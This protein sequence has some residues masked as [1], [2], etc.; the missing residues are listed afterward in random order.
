MSETPMATTNKL[1]GGTMMSPIVDPYSVYKR[2]RDDHPA[3]PVHTM[4]GIIHMITRYDDV[5]MV[6]KDGKTF[7]S[8]ANAR[9]I[10]I[11]MGRTILEME[12]K[13]HVRFRNIIAPFFGPRAMKAET[14]ELVS[15]II[16]RLIDEF[17]GAGSADLVQQF[18]FSFP[19][20]VMANIIGVFLIV[21]ICIGVPVPETRPR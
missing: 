20:E 4:M 7:S 12:G 1:F 16:N 19:M 11:V 2:L 21:L 13:E 18:T 5:E 10:G 17:V 8:K 9:G 14:G 6:L 15:S 3:L